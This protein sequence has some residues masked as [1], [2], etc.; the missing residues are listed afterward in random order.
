M[1]EF[2]T[3]DRIANQLRLR[4]STFAG[5]FLLV[6]GSSDKVFYERFVNKKVC[7]LEVVAGKIRVITVL[8]ILETSSFRGIL[9]IVDADFDRLEN[10][11]DNSRNFVSWLT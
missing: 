3:D 8:D 1:R 7:Q 10:S 4:R 2:L 11:A 5:T 9:G 6:E